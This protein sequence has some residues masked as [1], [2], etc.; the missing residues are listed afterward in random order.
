MKK[1]KWKRTVGLLFV[2]I[3]VALLS[4]MI[5]YLLDV[6]YRKQL[7][8]YTTADLLSK[9]VSEQLEKA[10][11]AARF[12]TTADRL[13]KLGMVYY[14]F[15]N[16]AKATQCYELAVAKNS[17]QWIW[18]YY[19]GYANLE[20]GELEAAIQH[21]KQVTKKDPTVA[22]AFYY[23]GEACQKLG[24]TEDATKYFATTIGLKKLHPQEINPLRGNGF[25]LETY[26]RFQLARIYLSTA[27]PDSAENML[28]E[29]LQQEISFGPAY[30]LLG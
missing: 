8:G 4:W 15:G 27:Q 11:A 17:D 6:P 3:A 22:T 10:T 30:R 19:L 7:P 12:F 14:S 28:T 1:N 5:K 25:S 16:Y 2:V 23:A 29:I 20:Q 13:G 26:A 9:P 24:L 18:N 21:F